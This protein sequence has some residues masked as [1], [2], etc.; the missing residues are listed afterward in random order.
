MSLPRIVSQNLA[1]QN[2]VSMHETAATSSKRFSCRASIAFDFG[3]FNPS[4]L[5]IQNPSH[6]RSNLLGPM[7]SSIDLRIL[8]QPAGFL[9]FL[10]KPEFFLTPQLFRLENRFRLNLQYLVGFHE[11][12]LSAF[13]E[14]PAI[15]SLGI[16]RRLRSVRRLRV[17]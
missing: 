13:D 4:V 10:F 16:F 12:D 7:L 17:L 1:S 5:Y 11:G 8:K 14:A 3:Q 9:S 2:L 15:L 6:L